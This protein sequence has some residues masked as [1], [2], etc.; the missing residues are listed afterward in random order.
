MSLYGDPD[1][2]D[3]LAVQIERHADDVRD[4]ASGMDAQ[5]AAMRWKSVAADRA[6]QTVTGDRRKL[7][8]TARRL[9]E[10]AVLLRRHAQ[11]VREILA[12]IQRIEQE[13]IGWFDHAIKEFND[14]VAEFTDLVENIAQ[15][16]VHWVT[17]E[18]PEPPKEPWQGW[19]YQPNNLPPSG[20]KQWLQVG[21]FMRKQ[22]AI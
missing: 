15:G 21:E 7:D 17:G 18:Q 2:L 10:A 14:A 11:E 16:V 6:R 3:H 20:D 13:V 5:A 22:G 12:M 19:P 4:R 8:E 1:E 9:D